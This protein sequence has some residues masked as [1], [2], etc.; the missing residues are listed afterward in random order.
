M[1]KASQTMYTVLIPLAENIIIKATC[2]TYKIH[3]K[4]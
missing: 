1:N 2:D 3:I 4:I